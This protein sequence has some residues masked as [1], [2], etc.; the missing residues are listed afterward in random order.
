M[1]ELRS[2][3]LRWDELQQAAV[4]GR[5]MREVDW[6]S[7]RREDV[8]RRRDPFAPRPVPPDR[9]ALVRQV[10]GPLPLGRGDAARI[11]SVRGDAGDPDIGPADWRG[12][13]GPPLAPRRLVDV[14]PVWTR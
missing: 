9:G 12:P 11:C 4:S 2:F 5:V 14:D 1:S 10:G 8:L 3:A 7:A 6:E 13:L